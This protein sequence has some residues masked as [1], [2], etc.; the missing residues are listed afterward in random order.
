LWLFFKFV[1]QSYFHRFVFWLQAKDASDAIPRL[2]L[3]TTQ[4]PTCFPVFSLHIC[5]QKEYEEGKKRQANKRKYHVL[6][7]SK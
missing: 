4:P 3:F 7:L 5:L 2:F 6:V 1:N